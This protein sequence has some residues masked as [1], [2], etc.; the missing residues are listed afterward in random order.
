MSDP[1]TMEPDVR[2]KR[3]ERKPS[4][5]YTKMLVPG[6]ALGSGALLTLALPNL[7][8]ADGLIDYAKCMVIGGTATLTAYGVNRLA[9][10]KGAVQAAIGTPGAALVSASS[11][12]TVGLGMFAA[13]Y[14]G[15]VV[16]EVDRLRMEDFG[17]AQAAYVE[18]QQKAAMEAA[19]VLPAVRGVADEFAAKEDCERG[20]SCVSGRGP[21]GEGPVYRA[22]TGERQRAEALAAQ[23]DAGAAR[24]VSGFEEINGLQSAYQRALNDESL[25]AEDRRTAARAAFMHIGQIGSAMAQ[26]DPVALVSGYAEEMAQASGAPVEVERLRQARAAALRSITASVPRTPVAPPVFP[27]QAG[28]SDTLAWAGH[29]LPIALIVGAV[30]LVLPIVLWFYTFAALRVVVMRG[31]PGERDEDAVPDQDA[32][33]ARGSAPKVLRRTGR[34][35]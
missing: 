7:T 2:L 30:E 14:S 21:G 11:V 32:H 16:E 23:L 8:E 4:P 13:T 33:Q 28:V 10:D 26:N 1:M 17:T 3:L 35:L 24:L 22:L 9:I 31:E 6:L 15:F 5:H 29:F 34:G 18:A 25:S 20:S 19:R 12:L 27:A